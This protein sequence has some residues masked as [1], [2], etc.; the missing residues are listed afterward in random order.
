MN[1]TIVMVIL[2]VTVLSARA[3]DYESDI[4]P[5]MKEHCFQ[6][7]SE[8][9]NKVKGNL[10]LD[11]LEDM[12]DYQRAKFSLIRPGNPKE[13]HFLGV[14]KMGEGDDDFMPRKGVAVPSKEIAL[15]EKWI[16]EG[17]PF[18][19]SGAEKKEGKGEL[20][21]TAMSQQT[22]DWK[23][24][25]GKIIKARFVRLAGDSV[26]LLLA[27]GKS[28]RYPLAKLSEES[29]AQAKKLAVDKAGI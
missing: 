11:D 14:L 26:M 1:G 23:N 25:E 28:Y 29:R 24:L 4:L 18:K 16:V 21:K 19:K 6:C 9:E 2:A 15:I 5:I 10:A 3:L 22:L 8:K 27:N 7:H 12:R 13:S 17:A 20:G